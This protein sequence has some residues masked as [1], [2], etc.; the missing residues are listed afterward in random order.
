MLRF[1][2]DFEVDAWSIFWRWNLIKIC[3]WTLILPEQV[4]LVSWTQP[5][6]SVV[7]LAMFMI[8]KIVITIIKP[9]VET[10]FTKSFVEG[11]SRWPLAMY[12]LITILA[13]NSNQFFSTSSTYWI[14]QELCWGFAQKTLAVLGELSSLRHFWGASTP[15]EK[16]VVSC[17]HQ[18]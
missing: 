11:L 12:A 13:I 10:V 1:G 7:S 4:T 14:S 18:S 9:L 3:F 17:S 2:W 15:T 16:V 5:P 6:G 8:N